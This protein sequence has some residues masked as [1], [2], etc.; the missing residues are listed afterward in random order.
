M[1]DGPTVT[2]VADW[3]EVVIIPG[4]DTPDVLVETPPQAEIVLSEVG[5]RGLAGAG[6]TVFEHQQLVA[7]DTWIVNHNLGHEPAAV[8]ILTLGRVEFEADITHVSDNQLVVQTVSP[9]TGI[10]R[11]M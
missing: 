1:I 4:D 9:S 3:P 10:V 6:A 7:S 8:Q 2:I 5:L 11:V